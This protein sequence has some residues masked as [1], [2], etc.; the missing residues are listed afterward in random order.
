MDPENPRES[1]KRKCVEEKGRR[2]E[3]EKTA[4]RA[5]ISLLQRSLGKVNIPMRLCSC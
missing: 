5:E 1:E 2:R 4:G 3:E